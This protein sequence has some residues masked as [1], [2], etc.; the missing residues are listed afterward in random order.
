MSIIQKSGR[1]NI[2]IH[3]VT[4][5]DALYKS[6]NLINTRITHPLTLS[7]ISNNPNVQ[8]MLLAKGL[9]REVKPKENLISEYQNYKYFVIDS[10]GHE[11]ITRFEKL[12][13]LV[14]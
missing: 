7:K 6:L 12:R 13:E 4:I 11:Y 2:T 5:Y 3:H 8:K 14:D 1:T 9:I 10:K